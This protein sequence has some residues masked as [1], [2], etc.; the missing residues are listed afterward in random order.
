LLY[1]AEHRMVAALGVRDLVIV[2]TDDAVLVADKSRSQESRK[3][4]NAR[5]AGAHRA[6]LTQPGL[7]ALGLL[8]GIDAGERFQVKRIMVKP[9]EA[10]LATDASPSADT[11]W[12]CRAPPSDAGRRGEALVENESIYIPIGTKHRLENVGRCRFSS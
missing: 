10:A 1:R 12:W 9:G 3:W 8:R 5:A 6:R 7:S 11:G 4:S 2:E